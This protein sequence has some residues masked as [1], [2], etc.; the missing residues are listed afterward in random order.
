MR[1]WKRRARVKGTVKND[2]EQL[3]EAKSR[4]EQAQ[5]ELSELLAL[6]RENHIEPMIR[7]AIQKRARGER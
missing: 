6:H 7:Q 5:R 1:F 2:D 4:L 3:E